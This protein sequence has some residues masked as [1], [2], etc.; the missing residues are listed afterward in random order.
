M[1]KQKNVH[2]KRRK[3][4]FGLLNTLINKLGFELHIPGYQFCGPGTKLEER[5]SRGEEGVNELDKGCKRHDI[6]YSES[7][8][9]EER[10]KADQIL[11]QVADQR[12]KSSDASLGE[13][14]AALGVKAAMKAKLKLGM[15]CKNTAK[16]RCMKT[17]IKKRKGKAGTR[18]SVKKSKRKIRLPRII[19]I[20]KSG[21]FLPLLLAGLGALGAMGGGA[22]GIAKAV[23]DAKSAAEQLKESQRH[24]KTMEA[25]AL[26]KGLYLRSPRKKGYGMY[27]RAPSKS[28]NYK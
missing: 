5:H 13:K 22:A 12:F 3:R 9:L 10:H 26:G 25:L 24:N 23:G 28:K 2:R 17:K 6:T 1:Y 16:S 8:N 14:I 7:N 11:A 18:N 19:P 20:P 21:G 27:L 4:G 15:G